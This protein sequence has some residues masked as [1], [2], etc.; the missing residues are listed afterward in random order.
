MKKTIFFILLTVIFIVGCS[1]NST[2]QIPDKE[3][4]NGQINEEKQEFEPSIKPTDEQIE[5]PEKKEMTIKEM[6]LDIYSIETD[7]THIVTN[8]GTADLEGLLIRLEEVI[9]SEKK[10]MIIPVWN[11]ENTNDEAINVFFDTFGGITYGPGRTSVTT[12][13]TPEK[14]P[15]QSIVDTPKL[16]KGEKASF[17][18]YPSKYVSGYYVAEWYKTDKPEE[19]FYFVIEVE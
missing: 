14:Y 19:I 15:A 6:L 2:Q 13:S 16:S 3:M 1:A 5:T 9:I 12:I 17:Y 4:T 10:E 11:A 8:D 18:C 7:D